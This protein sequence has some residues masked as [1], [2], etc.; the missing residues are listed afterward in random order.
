[1]LPCEHLTTTLDLNFPLTGKK[2][3]A[4]IP[5]KRLPILSCLSLHFVHTISAKFVNFIFT[6]RTKNENE[7]AHDGVNLCRVNID[8]EQNKE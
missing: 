3:V 4:M 2:E 8:N 6:Q 7:A 1:M 5:T